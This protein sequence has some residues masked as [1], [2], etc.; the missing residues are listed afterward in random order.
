MFYLEAHFP[1]PREDF[2]LI[3]RGIH[4]SLSDS[5]KV[6]RSNNIFDGVITISR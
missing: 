1:L 2:E 3:Q 6:L 4:V 5:S